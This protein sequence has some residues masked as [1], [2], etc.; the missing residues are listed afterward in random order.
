MRNLRTWIRWGVVHAHNHLKQWDADSSSNRGT[1]PV[2]PTSDPHPSAAETEGMSSP[3]RAHILHDSL[4]QEEIPVLNELLASCSS[5]SS[6]PVIRKW[7]ALSTQSEVEKSGS[8]GLEDS[9]WSWASESRSEDA[10]RRTSPTGGGHSRRH[11][12]V[13]EESAAHEGWGLHLMTPRTMSDAELC[14]ELDA[15]LALRAV[16]MGCKDDGELFF[17]YDCQTMN[18]LELGDEQRQRSISLGVFAANSA[19]LHRDREAALA[20]VKGL[21]TPP[22]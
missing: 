9:T 5:T 6:S 21:K 18:G 10:L 12:D 22:K 13:I 17:E 7:N 15:D 3:C 8:D 20:Y 16:G 11:A 14:A 2:I 4:C 19:S 1:L